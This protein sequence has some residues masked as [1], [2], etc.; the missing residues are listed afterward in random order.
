M[1]FIVTTY[2]FLAT[3]SSLRQKPSIFTCLCF[4]AS[5]AVLQKPCLEGSSYS[6]FGGSEKK[7]CYLLKIPK[8]QHKLVWEYRQ[9]KLVSCFLNNAAKI[10]SYGLKISENLKV[11]H[12]FQLKDF[13]HFR[14]FVHTSCLGIF[15][16]KLA[17]EFTQ[18]KSDIQ[19]YKFNDEK[20][21]NDDQTVL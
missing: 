18:L 21:N 11:K 16:T 9:G 19:K 2:N 5:V 1:F 4:F 13:F 12:F 15:N 20:F 7:N 10:C 3:G 14:N 6:R 8:W 17:Q